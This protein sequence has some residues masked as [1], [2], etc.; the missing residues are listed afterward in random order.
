MSAAFIFLVTRLYSTLEAM[1]PI[2]AIA[3]LTVLPLCAELNTDLQAAVKAGDAKLA[4]A[5]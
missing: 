2:L 4:T 1:V 5:C 3:L